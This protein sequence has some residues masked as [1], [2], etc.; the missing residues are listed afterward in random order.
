MATVANSAGCP[1]IAWAIV[2]VPSIGEGAARSAVIMKK[3]SQ[4]GV[5]E[6]P[7]YPASPIGRSAVPSKQK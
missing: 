1:A 4:P 5:S 6:K 3:C 7:A 2:S